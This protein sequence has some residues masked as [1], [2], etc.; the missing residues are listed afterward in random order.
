MKDVENK[1]VFSK[2]T[3]K[4][5]HVSLPGSQKRVHCHTAKPELSW[6]VTNN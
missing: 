6:R 3:V 1:T 5:L 4:C 2:K